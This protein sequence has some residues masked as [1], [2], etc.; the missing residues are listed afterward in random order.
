MTTLNLIPPSRADAKRQASSIKRWT[1]VCSAYAAALLC[2]WIALT[3]TTRPNLAPIREEL[4]TIESQIVKQ[5]SEAAKLQ[6]QLA[7]EAA[8]LK[9]SRSV[10]DQPDWSVLMKLVAGAL[11]NRVT[12]NQVAVNPLQ[13]QSGA[14]RAFGE[15]PGAMSAA[16][17]ED[18]ASNS[19]YMM[20][21]SGMASTQSEAQKLA[22][23]LEVAGFFDRV[24]LVQTSRQE[25]MGGHAIAFEILCPFGAK[26]DSP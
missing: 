25:F 23:R 7:T 21:I 3:A 5:Q 16:M 26:E 14:G 15:R 11:G 4:A 9:A 22:L 19:T 6:A 1:I 13:G 8:V 20:S 18:A 24:K 17:L 12:L 2:V 10:G